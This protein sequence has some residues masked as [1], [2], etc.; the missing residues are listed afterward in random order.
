MNNQKTGN[1]LNLALDATSR[2]REASMNLNAGYEKDTQRWKLIIRYFGAASELETDEIVITPLLGNYGIADIPQDQIEGFAQNPEVE[3]I[4][5]PKRLYFAAYEGRQTSCVNP[6]Q[7]QSPYLFGKGILIACIDS[8]VDYTHPDFRNEDGSTRILR[9]W[10][11]SI[12]G[13]PPKGYRIGS[14]YTQEQINRALEANTMAEREALVPSIDTSGHGTAVLGIA[15]G[16]GRE[17]QGTERGVAP[18][19]SLLVVKLGIRDPNG[20]PRTTELMQGVDYAIRTAQ[21]LQMPVVIN[22]SFGNSYGAHN[23]TSLVETYLNQA[24]GYGRVTLCVGTGNEGNRAGH[25][26]G[27]V[28]QGENYEAELGIGTYEPAMNLQ[29]WKNYQDQMEISLVHP[30]G[31]IIGPLEQKLGT[32]RYRHAG[33]QLLIYYGKPSPYSTSQEIYI[34]FLPTESYIDSGIWRIRLV[35]RRILQG[36]FSMWLPGGKTVGEATRFYRPTPETTLT[37]PSTA[38]SAISVAAYDSR[39]QSYADFS[40]RG[41]TRLPVQIKPDL[42]APGVDIRAPRP[43]GGYQ[44]VTG[45]SFAT[46][47][48]SGAAALL[49]EW[50]IVRGNDPYLYGQKMKSYLINGA[51]QL[52]GEREWPNARVGWGTLCTA[53]SL[54]EI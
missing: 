44:T 27:S 34:D 21:E 28:R 37:I 52:P 53:Q 47:F 32:Q 42:A 4:E 54:P 13:N 24:V 6:V 30:D 18:E 36:E 23:G 40:G 25:T 51:K 35:P 16:N 3:Y 7:N 43:G 9:L 49:M 10:D 26:A 33:T 31:T 39:R 17:S 1:T 38:L 15:A 12:P 50:G 11:Q 20:F 29:I 8:G 22:L 48:V 45:T 14:E 46:P 41:Y 2:E 5:A 19:S